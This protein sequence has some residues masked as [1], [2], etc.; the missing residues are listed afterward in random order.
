MASGTEQRGRRARLDTNPSEALYGILAAMAVVAA[1]NDGTVDPAHMAWSTVLTLLVFWVAHVYT[2]VL[3]HRLVH[4]HGG[5]A[6]VRE[7]A[8][9]EL[10]IA[11][12]P[13]PVVVV[14]GLGAAGLLAPRFAANL[15]LATGVVQLFLWGLA[16]GRGYGRSWPAS[17]GTGLVDA[18]LGVAVVGLKVVVH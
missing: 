6:V 18:A 11:E 3:E 10:P 15:A 9:R 5:V 7:I 8:V 16:G 17:V 14:L 4:R 2:N 1:E 12:A 13:A